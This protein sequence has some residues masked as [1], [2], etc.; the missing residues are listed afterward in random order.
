MEAD[1]EGQQRHCFK[2]IR[3]SGNNRGRHPVSSSIFCMGVQRLTH[4][5]TDTTHAT[6]QEQPSLVM[7]EEAPFTIVYLVFIMSTWN[8]FIFP[9]HLFLL[10]LDFMLHGVRV[11]NLLTYAHTE[12]GVMFHLHLDHN[13]YH[14]I[15]SPQVFPLSIRLLK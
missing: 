11:F 1:R 9:F 3:W 15:K 5:F 12:P 7:C 2:T 14:F 4:M 8:D 10:S 6:Y 13:T